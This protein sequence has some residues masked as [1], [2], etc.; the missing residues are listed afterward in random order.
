VFT[1]NKKEQNTQNSTITYYH[2]VNANMT[3]QVETR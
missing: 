2:L 3:K 1:Q